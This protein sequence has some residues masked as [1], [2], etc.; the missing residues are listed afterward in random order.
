VA[1]PTDMAFEETK[2]LLY[3]CNRIGIHAPTLFLNLATPDGKCSLCS[4]LY[5]RESQVGKK[6]Q[7]AF[8]KMHQTL[9]Y[10]RTEPRGLDRLRELGETLYDFDSIVDL[11]AG[12]MA[13]NPIYRR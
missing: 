10:R 7:Q 11:P 3:A 4:A 12:L 9:I 13:G 1:I 6:F 5:Q 2:D 8:S